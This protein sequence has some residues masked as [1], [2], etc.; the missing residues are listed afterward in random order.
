MLQIPKSDSLEQERWFS[1][2]ASDAK[3]YFRCVKKWVTLRRAWAGHSHHRLV[4][5]LPLP[6]RTEYQ[7]NG[8]AWFV[9]AQTLCQMETHLKRPKLTEFAE[10]GGRIRLQ[11]VPD[12]FRTGKG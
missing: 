6:L 8:K 9:E 1:P 5:M 10:I 3:T 11:A 4:G 12:G 2:K 7:Y